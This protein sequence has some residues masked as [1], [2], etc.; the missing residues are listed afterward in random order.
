MYSSAYVYVCVCV[1]VCMYAFGCIHACMPVYM[2][3]CLDIF[4]CTTHIL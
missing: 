2:H 1:S 3:V 4:I